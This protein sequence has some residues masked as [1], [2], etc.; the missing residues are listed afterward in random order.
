MHGQNVYNIVRAAMSTVHPD[1]R[2]ITLRAPAFDY[3]TPTNQ[4]TEWPNIHST[5]SKK[6]LNSSQWAEDGSWVKVKYIGV[7]Y[8]LPK[9]LVKVGDLSLS[10]SGTDLLTFTKY[11]GYDPEVSASGNSDLYGGADFG[12]FPIPKTI[13]FGITLDF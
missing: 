11:K 3:W 10:V 1:S 9:N 12:T 13:T 5:S 7:T 2:A 4:D 6:R 8:R